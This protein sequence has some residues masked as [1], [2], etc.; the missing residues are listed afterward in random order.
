MRCQIHSEMALIEEEEGRLEAS[1]THLQKA[2]KLD[3]G[4]QRER[5]SR[6]LHLLQLRGTL[7][8][9]PSC[10]TDKAAVLLQQVLSI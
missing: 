7:N 5:L 3:T 4:S 10:N 1:L 8:Q 9:N 6:A 2:I